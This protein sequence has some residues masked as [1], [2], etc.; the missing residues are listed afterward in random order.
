VE[1]KLDSTSN[2]T[3]WKVIIALVLAMG[4]AISIV[5]LSINELVNAGHITASESTLYS[6]ILG[7][8]IGALGTYLGLQE[9]NGHSQ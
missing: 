8:L 5:L 3:D 2:V 1:C 7:A 9:R 6:T 4:T